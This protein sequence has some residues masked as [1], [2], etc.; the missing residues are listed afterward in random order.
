MDTD[1]QKIVLDN[2]ELGVLIQ[3]LIDRLPN[4]T[5]VITDE[6]LRGYLILGRYVKTLYNQVDVG[7]SES[8]ILD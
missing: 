4:D 7:Q 2:C 1:I 8:E 3:T 5:E 6:I